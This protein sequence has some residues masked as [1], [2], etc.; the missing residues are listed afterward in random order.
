[1]MQYAF[2]RRLT[3]KILLL[4]ANSI[5]KQRPSNKGRCKY[6]LIKLGFDYLNIVQA[7]SAPVTVALLRAV[8]VLPTA[9]YS[10]IAIAT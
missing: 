4:L 1:M 9:S 2:L 8:R 6:Y 5:K 7:A 10:S 3:A